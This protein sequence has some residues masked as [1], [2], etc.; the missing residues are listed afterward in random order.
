M[1]RWTVNLWR[2]F[3]GWRWEVRLGDPPPITRICEEFYLFDYRVHSSSVIQLLGPTL[4]IL[5]KEELLLYSSARRLG[6]CILQYT[7]S[8]SFP[9][10][11]LWSYS[12][13]SS[14]TTFH[15]IIPQSRPPRRQSLPF[16][17]AFPPGFSFL[18]C[19]RTYMYK[20]PPSWDGHDP[21][22][23]RKRY[24]GV[25][26]KLNLWMGSCPHFHLCIKRWTPTRSRCREKW[27]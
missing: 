18:L 26:V 8:P 24:E 1:A 3:S 7:K 10:Q 5:L 17:S 16:P 12:S 23:K 27:R 15:H 21:K 20:K 22:K 9:P 6:L 19:D 4:E 2:F 11:K 14:S 25:M 13:P